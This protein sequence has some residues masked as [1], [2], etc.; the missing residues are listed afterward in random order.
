[1]IYY[2]NRRGEIGKTLTWLA[3][4]PI[5][6]FIL[7]LFLLATVSLKAEN[8]TGEIFSIEGQDKEQGII[9][10][11]KTGEIFEQRSLT[12][13]LDS[14]ADFSGKKTGIYE[15]VALA[16]KD[17]EEA[18]AVEAKAKSYFTSV[19]RLQ[20]I[21]GEEKILDSGNGACFESAKLEIAGR[22]IR[23][24]EVKNE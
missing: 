8:K 15:L 2:K 19:Y 23:F 24:C 22:E 12:A 17:S 18:K 11:Y 21:K 5:I 13:F 3:A 1:M 14:E 6:V 9:G 7:A 16:E 20:I 10:T 4:L